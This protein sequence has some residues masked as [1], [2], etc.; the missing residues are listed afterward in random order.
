MALHVP[1]PRE[2]SASSFDNSYPNYFLHSRTLAVHI[3]AAACLRRLFL[4]D[5]S[6]ELCDAYGIDRI[7][8]SFADHFAAGHR[9]LDSDGW[10]VLL[11]ASALFHAAIGAAPSLAL[12]SQL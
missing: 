12:R 11:M 6:L 7:L 5:V 1:P 4:E 10:H 8:Q 2:T 9:E 3:G